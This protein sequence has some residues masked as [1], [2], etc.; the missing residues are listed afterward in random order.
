MLPPSRIKEL[1]DHA[2]P[3]RVL[4]SSSPTSFGSTKSILIY[5]SSRWWTV[6]LLFNLATWDAEEAS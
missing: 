3:L 2:G 4:L 5:Q 1:V 6:Y